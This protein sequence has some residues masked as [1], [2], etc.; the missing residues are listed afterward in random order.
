MEQNIT[1]K[2]IESHAQY[3][4]YDTLKHCHLTRTRLYVF[5]WNLGIFIVFVTIFGFTLYLCAK[6]KKTNTDKRNAVFRDQQYV[7]DKIRAMKELDSYRNQQNS[8]S[9]LPTVHSSGY[10]Y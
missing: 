6:Y 1:P 3:Y 9:Q 8:I 10:S 4:L 7:L 2:L 5:A